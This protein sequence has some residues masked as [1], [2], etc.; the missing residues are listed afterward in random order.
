MSL[1]QNGVTCWC[2]FV[3]KYIVSTPRA[4]IFV[5]KNTDF[6]PRICNIWL[7]GMRIYIQIIRI[8][9]TP[10]DDNINAKNEKKAYNSLQ[11]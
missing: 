11:K 9:R 8:R 6:R 5:K 4:Y 10:H 7:I 3:E 1:G 2:C